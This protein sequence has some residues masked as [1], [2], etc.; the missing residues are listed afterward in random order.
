MNTGGQISEFEICFHPIEKRSLRRQCKA[1]GN[2]RTFPGNK[3][4]SGTTDHAGRVPLGQPH[5]QTKIRKRFSG[6]SHV[7]ISVFC[8]LLFAE[9]QS[10]LIHKSVHAPQIWSLAVMIAGMSRPVVIELLAF[11]LACT[12]TYFT[13]G[14]LDVDI[15]LHCDPRLAGC[16][17]I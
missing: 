2:F 17:C 15:I 4:R 11:V 14:T 3:I 13:Y 16:R 5:G 9:L 1:K 8:A 7:A 12:Y 10:G 6:I